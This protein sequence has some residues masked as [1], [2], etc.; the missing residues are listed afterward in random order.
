MATPTAISNRTPLHRTAVVGPNGFAGGLALDWANGQALA[1]TGVSA[2]SAAFDATNDRIVMVSV[3][4][5][6]SVGGCWISVGPAP[7]AA[8]GAGS[9]WIAQSAGP[10]P[11]YVPAGM[12]IA[13][14]Q[15]ATGGTLSMIPALIAG[16]A[17]T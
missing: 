13:G 10:V 4:G 2:A 6:S 3:G 7:V 11:V 5:A 16:T 17:G 12:L 15:G 1:L 14:V 8:A 9:Q